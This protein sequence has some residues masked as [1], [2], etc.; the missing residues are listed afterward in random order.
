MSKAVSIQELAK[1]VGVSPS[2]VSRA[3]NNSGY[4]NANLKEKIKKMAMEIDY[5]PD[6]IA[7]SLRTKINHLIGLCIPDILNPF[8]PEVARGVQDAAEEMGFTVAIYNT[9]GDYEK[10]KN[11]VKSLLANHLDGLILFPVS[12]TSDELEI[13][14][15]HQLPFVVFDSKPHMLDVDTIAVD[16]FKGAYS[17]TEYLIQQGHR[18]IGFM[19]GPINANEK[20]FMGYEHCLRKYGLKVS[21]NLIYIDK[22]LRGCGQNGIKYFSSLEQKPSAIFVVNDC[23]AIEAIQTANSMN[24]RVPQ[25]LSIVGFDDISPSKIITPALSTV[26]QPKY[27][28]GKKATEILIGRILGTHTKEK[29]WI[30][31]EPELIIRDSSSCYEGGEEQKIG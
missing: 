12:I 16:D 11:L 1:K 18:D 14:I 4:V 29:Q 3:L 6:K 24:I 19:G 15:K 13:L 20:R 27:E 2:T 26:A 25:E 30:V 17:A 7:R 8:F 28:M 22:N 21:N 9:D 31:V 10:E 5:Y 23:I